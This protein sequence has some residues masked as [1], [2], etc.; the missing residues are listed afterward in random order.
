VSADKVSANATAL[1][2][3]FVSATEID[4]VV[5]ASLLKTSGSLLISVT[6]P[7]SKT[8]SLFLTIAPPAPAASVSPASISF[9]PVMVGSKSAAQNVT[10]SNTGTATLH[11]SNVTVSG[12]YS[13]TNNCTAVAPGANCVV[14][15]VFQPAAPNSREG[16]LAIADDDVSTQQTVGLHGTGTDVQITPG[17]TGSTSTVAAGQP[18]NYAL[19]IAPAGGFTG[20][21]T[22][23]CTSLPKYAACAITPPTTTLSTAPVN[24]AVTITTSQTQAAS[25][26]PLPIVISAGVFWI[27]LLLVALLLPP[28]RTLR[29]SR[30]ATATALVTLTLCVATFIFT[31]CGGGSSSGST[32]P[33][34][35]S[36]TLTTP[37]GTY[38]VNFVVTSQAGSRTMPLTLTVQ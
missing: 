12:D 9:D 38:T 6:T 13:Q 2:S 28:R 17:S 25:L 11:V 34:P 32:P 33:P 23:S 14:A 24:I 16:T 36:T 5:P 7:A 18:A 4:A 21:V 31:G 8:S 1:Q 30:F 37:Q 27:G 22:F 15:V 3:T 19:T 26:S 20:A 35:Q 29:Q 10:I